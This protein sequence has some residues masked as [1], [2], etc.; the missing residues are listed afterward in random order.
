MRALV[1]LALLAG[2]LGAQTDEPEPKGAIRGVVKDSFG[3]AVSGV[4]VELIVI[5]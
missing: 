4:T 2:A 1:T 5:N 3:A